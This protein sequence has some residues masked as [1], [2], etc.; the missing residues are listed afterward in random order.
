MYCNLEDMDEYLEEHL[1][2]SLF[3][4]IKL[5][6]YR[7]RNKK[8]TEI[9]RQRPRKFWVKKIYKKGKNLVNIIT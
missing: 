9:R 3:L 4:L 6:R 7:L 5:R 8:I 1:L 2:L